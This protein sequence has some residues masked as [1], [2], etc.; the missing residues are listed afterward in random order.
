MGLKLKTVVLLM[1]FAAVLGGCV[2]SGTYQQKE[3][4]SQMLSKNLEE[5]RSSYFEMQQKYEKLAGENTTLEADLK[6]QKDA[7][8]E[9]LKKNEKLAGTNSELDEKI[10]KLLTD[11]ADSKA[12]N[13]KMG[14]SLADLNEKLKKLNGNIADSTS[15][16]SKLTLDNLN[17]AEKLRKLTFELDELKFTNEKLSRA[18]K[19]EN[20]LKTVGDHFESLQQKVDGL[21]AENTKL[22]GTLVEMRNVG[23]LPPP[24]TS[25]NG[26][27]PKEPATAHVRDEALLEQVR[28]EKNRALP[29]AAEKK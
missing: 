17:L 3:K 28:K 4:E 10:K 27:E 8:A 6:K 12:E 16:N 23:K 20:L 29:A 19:P 25:A 21:T 2:S 24:E 15:E 22:K 5:A 11:L 14:R 9:S 18:V 26:A 7:A 1:G 13:D